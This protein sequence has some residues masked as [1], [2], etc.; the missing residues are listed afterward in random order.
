MDPDMML[1]LDSL[2]EPVPTEQDYRDQARR[3][4]Q[5][6]ADNMRVVYPPNDHVPMVIPQLQLQQQQHQDQQVQQAQAH[7]GFTPAEELIFHAHRQQSQS[8]VMAGGGLVRGGVHVGGVRRAG[9]YERQQQ[10]GYS[11]SG[12][13]G[14]LP[15][16]VEDSF[17]ANAQAQTHLPYQHP[18]HQQQQQ[19]QQQHFDSSK[20]RHNPNIHPAHV[21]ARLSGYDHHQQQQQQQKHNAPST[22]SNVQSQASSYNNNNHIQTSTHMRSTTLPPP[23]PP[24]RSSASHPNNSNN[25]PNQ[26]HYQ[27]HQNSISLPTNSNF[28]ATNL[29]SAT[30]GLSNTNPPSSNN[31]TFFDH[32]DIQHDN[33]AIIHPVDTSNNYNNKSN[34]NNNNYDDSNNVQYVHHQFQHADSYDIDVSSPPIISPTLTYN[35]SRT[36]P[37][38]LSPATPFFGS[39]GP[40]GVEGFESGYGQ[41]GKKIRA[42]SQ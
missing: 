23:P 33:N 19:Q 13:V 3:N 37:S 11:P 31:N 7:N 27:Q 22:Y 38:T 2:R 17:H 14:M 35:S 29:Y 16:T 25:N 18:Y 5:S 34:I 26:R 24:L 20:A 42:G 15:P 9:G 40:A 1:L 6:L 32:H 28:R 10:Q 4:V 41:Q 12:Q 21:N 36:T 8:Q 30:K 39:F